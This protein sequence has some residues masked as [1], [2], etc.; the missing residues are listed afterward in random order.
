MFEKILLNI[1]NLKNII[2]IIE[3]IFLN[4]EENTIS[5][6]NSI[7]PILLKYLSIFGCINTKSFINFKINN[8]DLLKKINQILYNFISEKNNKLLKDK[9]LEDNIKEVI[10][11]LDIFKIINNNLNGDLSKLNN[12]DYNSEYIEKFNNSN[13]NNN[14]F[15]IGT[16]NKENKNCLKDKLKNL[17]K[18][19]NLSFLEKAKSNK[20]MF[21]EINSQLNNNINDNNEDEIMCFFC[22]N[23]IKLNSF[24][25]AYGKSGY[26][27][28]DFFYAN[29]IKS[30]INSEIIKLTK[31]NENIPKYKKNNNLNDLLKQIISCGHFFHLSCFKEKNNLSFSCPL[32]LKKQNIL[33]PPLINFHD[34]YNFLKSYKIEQIFK[35]ENIAEEIELEFNLFINIVNEFLSYLFNSEGQ[36]N[37]LEQIFPMFKRQFNYL[38]NIFYYNGTNFH[39]NQQIEINKNIILALRYITKSKIIDINNIIDFIIQ[40]LTFLINGPKE[41][42]NIINNYENLHYLNTLIKIFLYL[43]IL[44]EYEEI[45]KFSIYLIYIFLPYFSF[46]FYLRNLI[47]KKLFFGKKAKDSINI[48]NLMNY[49]KVNNQQMLDSFKL[50]LQKIL[51]LKLFTDYNN[52]NE[53]I[54]SFN[55]LNIKNLLSLLNMEKIYELLKKND[56]DDNFIN[57]FEVLSKIINFNGVFHGKLGNNYDYKKIFNMLINNIKKFQNEEYEFKNELFVQFSPLKFEFIHLDKNIFDFIEKYLEKPCIECL[58]ISRSY[59]ICLICGNKICN[60][61]NCNKISDHSMLCGGKYC[62]MI[63]MDDTNVSITENIGNI[64]ELSS[65]YINNEGIG[66]QERKIGNEFNLC[67]KKEELFFR[68][69]ICYD[70]NLLQ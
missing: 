47:V 21:K 67:K 16:T 36:N 28:Q 62:I 31:G 69:F 8:G 15:N 25:V 58:E 50:F 7:L 39:K 2:K 55:E 65:L 48:N 30:S 26:L 68:N 29:S 6:K 24:E 23:S 56:K 19:K 9:D 32:C 22:R 17:M 27:F 44:F 49:F 59:Y 35:N 11:Q 18:K 45:K 12:Y 53:N 66:P 60:T 70:F 43:S 40:E 63:N 13:I 34:K 10:K 4:E 14:K 5:I 42:E 1:Y 3:K 46:G 37:Y 20:E 41:N 64:K 52:I 51:I 61:N 57:I 38:E 54:N 33:I